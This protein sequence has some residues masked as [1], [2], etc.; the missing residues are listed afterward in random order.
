MIETL[1]DDEKKEL[2]MSAK[3]FVIHPQDAQDPREPRLGPGGMRA[4]CTSI[5]GSSPGMV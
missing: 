5:L 1:S 2:F 4:L 3:Q